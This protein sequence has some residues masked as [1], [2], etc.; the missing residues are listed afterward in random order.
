MAR[1][2]SAAVVAM[3]RPIIIIQE[4]REWHTPAGFAC[5]R[6]P[7]PHRTPGAIGQVRPQIG[8]TRQAAPP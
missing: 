5:C 8:Q 6:P 7:R 3:R 2:G 1:C 4:H